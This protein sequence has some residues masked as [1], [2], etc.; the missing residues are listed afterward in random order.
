[1]A[2]KKRRLLSNLQSKRLHLEENPESLFK[3]FIK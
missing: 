1:M 2:V 3:Y